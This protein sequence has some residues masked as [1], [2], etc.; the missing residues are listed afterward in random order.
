MLKEGERQ[1]GRK[2]GRSCSELAVFKGSGHLMPW[3]SEM[4]L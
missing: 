2:G 4:A 1:R 3:K